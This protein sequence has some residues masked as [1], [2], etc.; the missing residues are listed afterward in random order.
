MMTCGAA[1]NSYAQSDYLDN[2]RFYEELAKR[3]HEDLLLHLLE[4]DPPG[5]PV[6]ASL[7]QIAI[8]EKQAAKPSLSEEDRDAI[9]QRMRETRSGL[10]EQFK[11]HPQRPIWLTQQAEY[12]LVTQL[13]REQNAM[14]FALFGVPTEKQAELFSKAAVDAFLASDQAMEMLFIFQSELPNR[15]GHEQRVN[16]GLWSRLMDD[17]FA[18][19]TPFYHG[20]SAYLVS[21]LPS[22]HPYYQ[23]LGQAGS[24]YARETQAKDP[25]AERKRLRDLAVN[26]LQAVID[27]RNFRNPHVK[28]MA[29]VMVALALT[30][31]D[32][33]MSEASIAILDQVMTDRSND[34]R[35]YHLAAGLA[36][37]HVLTEVKS[38][39]QANE[40]TEQLYEHPLV[41]DAPLFRVLVADQRHR[42]ARAQIASMP[43][44]LR[45]D[46]IEG[47]FAPYMQLFAMMQD[48]QQR[49]AVQGYVYQRWADRFASTTNRSKLPGA[50]QM[51][52]G[53]IEM[54]R[55]QAMLNDGQDAEEAKRLLKDAVDWLQAASE[56]SDSPAVVARVGYN[57]AKAQYLQDTESVENIISAV[58]AMAEIAD[59]YPDQPDAEQ[60]M[61]D[62]MVLAYNTH[63][64]FGK[65][66]AVNEAL[67]KVAVV[68]LE[69]YPIIPTADDMRLYISDVVYYEAGEYLKAVEVL[70]GVPFSHRDFF[71]A[72]S[73]ALRCYLK[74]LEDPKTATTDIDAQLRAIAASLKPDAQ[75]RART[76]GEHAS[77]ARIF[78]GTSQI[79]LARLELLSNQFKPAIAALSNIQEILDRSHQAELAVMREAQALRIEILARSKQLDAAIQEARQLMDDSPDDAAPIIDTMLEQLEAEIERIRLAEFTEVVEREKT[80]LLERR[81]ELGQLAMPLAELLM[82]WAHAQKAQGVFS[83]EEMVPFSLVLAKAQRMAGEPA[84]SVQTIEPLVDQY[85]FIEV[86][87]SYGESLYALGAK[88]NDEA[89]MTQAF[90]QFAMILQ[91]DWSGENKMP[92]I[93]WNAQMRQ[94]QTLDIL[95]KDA[96]KDIPLRVRQLQQIHDRNLGGEPYRS[97]LLRLEQKYRGALAS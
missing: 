94:M 21:R 92:E 45:A 49:N 1:V 46:A 39:N 93:W 53:L 50:V 59:Q 54:N 6:E 76:R 32:V 67:R 10:I 88:N 23:Q 95:G 9:V 24:E 25:A 17:Y 71:L 75:Q 62:A 66:A 89:I 20:W 36:R 16:S 61:S 31:R 51:G 5:D 30:D 81:T 85:G 3:G 47:A 18:R 26:R 84:L 55:A 43:R 33:A 19:W 70:E 96:T 97:Q 2:A 58:N 64:K 57:L 44:D 90:Q 34:R 79:A 15:P 91:T 56:G 82:R 42:I 52:I 41:R 77:N 73:V 78:L 37:S 60:A 86:I 83:E 7:L 27:D 48:E 72:R 38:F 80:A 63:L 29:R 65:I 68:L 28:G 4:T 40:F 14:E 11:D 13:R 87:H 69:K 35:V 74:L 22:S 12:V 8:Y